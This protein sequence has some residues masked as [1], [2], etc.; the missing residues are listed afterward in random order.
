MVTGTGRGARL[1]AA[2]AAVRP[3]S[4]AGLSVAAVDLASGETVSYGGR[5]FVTAS[6][7]KVDILAA[8]LLGAQ[9]AGREPTAQERSYAAAMIERSD[10]DAASA[11]WDRIGRAA[12]LN[13]A[14]ARL[15]LTETTGGDG[16]LW[17]LTRTTAVDRLRLLRQVFG[18]DAERS[19]LGE[20]ARAYAR[21]LMRRVV[22]D[23]A[24]GVP[25][26]ADPGTAWAV[27]NGWLPRDATGL[28]VVH[29]VGCVTVGGRVCLMAVLSDGNASRARGVAMVERAAAA[30]RSVWQ[31]C[32]AVGRADGDGGP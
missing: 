9:D 14:N 31:E 24:W 28:W 32:P 4:G 11:L 15:G 13:A 18:E 8:L 23:Q 22:P 12:G 20:D 26:V 29:S 10:N 25:A 27:K 6:V 17:G 2:V 7:V 3:A 21:G 1:A 30:A 19:E 5:A 16:T